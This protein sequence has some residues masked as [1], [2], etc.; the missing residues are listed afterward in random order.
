MMEEKNLTSK[1]FRIAILDLYKEFVKICK[2]KQLTHWL[3]FGT[4]LGAIRH[5]DFIPWDDDF[6]V[7]MPRRDYEKLYAYFKSQSNSIRHMSLFEYRLVKNYPYCVCRLNDNR[8]IEIEPNTRQKYG[9][10]INFDIYILDG[11]NPSDVNQIKKLKKLRRIIDYKTMQNFPKSRNKFYGFLK[12]ILL[13]FFRITSPK[14]TIKKMNKIASKYS[15][16]DSEFCG[17]I[18]WD[19]RFCDFKTEWFNETIYTDFHGLKCPIPKSFDYLLK[20]IYK[21]YLELPPTDKRI[22]YHISNIRRK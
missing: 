12:R 16:G 13:P 7:F 19:P 20:R 8:F 5:K 15:F 2:E 14:K 10:G 22:G 21:N 6:D 4:L 3:A 1:E 11:S 17:D 9:L 18:V